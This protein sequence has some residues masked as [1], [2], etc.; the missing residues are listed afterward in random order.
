MIKLAHCCRGRGSETKTSVV[1]GLVKV[2]GRSC[3]VHG[4][5]GG[6]RN[7]RARDPFTTTSGTS[8]LSLGKP[9]VRGTVFGRR[10]IPKSGE[11]DSRV[12]PDFYLR[13]VEESLL[14]RTP[15]SLRSSELQARVCCGDGRLKSLGYVSLGFLLRRRD[16]SFQR[17]LTEEDSRV[18]P[19][20]YLR[21]VEESLLGRT[22]GSL[23]SSEL[24][25]SVCCGDGRLKSLGYV[26]LGFLIYVVGR[27]PFSVG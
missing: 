3:S 23:H 19:D 2:S 16:V 5:G 17:R 13:A 12:A 14:G 22:P 9:D 15:G 26:S 25:A 7:G 1:S 18:A 20:I 4:P 27:F 10:Q 21:A 8:D 24:Q 11:E 6:G